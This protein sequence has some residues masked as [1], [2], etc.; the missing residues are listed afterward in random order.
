MAQVF[1]IVKTDA[2]DRLVFGWANISVTKDGKTFFDLQDDNVPSVDLERAAYG[3]VLKSGNLGVNHEGPVTGRV[4]ESFLITP[5][6]LQAMGLVA[7]SADALPRVGWWVGFKV[8]P[9]TFDLVEKK[10]VRMFSIHG[11]AYRE[12]TVDA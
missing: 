11:K 9:L 4:V 10:Q 12:E 6:K 5:E 7:K 1:E 2:H 8:D 3:F